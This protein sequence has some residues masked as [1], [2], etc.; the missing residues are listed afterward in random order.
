MNPDMAKAKKVFLE[1]VRVF[2]RRTGAVYV[3]LA[4][5]FFTCMDASGIH[6]KAVAS[7]ISRLSPESFDYLVN[8]VEAGK[9]FDR[10]E[11]DHYLHYFEAADWHMRERPDVNSLLGFCHYYLGNT[12]KAMRYYEKAIEYYPDYFT[13]YFNLGVIY[14][15][16]KDYAKAAE[17]FERANRTILK[18]NLTFVSEARLFYPMVMNYK[19]VAYELSMRLKKGYH[20]NYYLLVRSLLY[21]ED[22]MNVL[23]FANEALVSNIDE[24]GEFYYFLGH[25]TFELGKYGDAVKMFKEALAKNPDFAEAYYDLGQTMQASG[26]EEQGAVMLQKAAALRQTKGN[27]LPPDESIH[28]RAY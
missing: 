16:Q 10:E 23:I 9:P 4:L 1:A 28:I 24:N 14:Y 5:V 25:A 17:L 8:V 6:W 11:L 7:A 26:K 27:A 12:D 3:L 19:D 21:R 20:D 15:Q 13:F 22:Y 18:E 2:F